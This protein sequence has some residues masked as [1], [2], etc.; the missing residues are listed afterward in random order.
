LGIGTKTQ[1]EFSFFTCCTGTAG[2][3]K[4]RTIGLQQL[5]NF[6]EDEFLQLHLMGPCTITKLKKD[7]KENGLIFSNN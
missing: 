7:L 2:F 5:S 3:R 1:R 6:S 4:E